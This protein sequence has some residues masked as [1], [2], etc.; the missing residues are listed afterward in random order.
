M[1]NKRRRRVVVSIL[2]FAAI[3][4]LDGCQKPGP[5][6]AASAPLELTVNSWVGWGPLF[7]AQEK[8]FFDGLNV[9][10]AFTEDAGARRSAMLAGQVDGYAS[11]VDNLAI[12]ATF[13]VTG[14]TV[15]CFDES[16]GADGIVARQN[17]TWAN[18][19]GHKVAVQK[20]LP[21][22]FL[23]L[24]ALA[25]HGLKPD[26]VAIL[27]LDADKAGSGFVSG[28]LDVA[29]TWE[30]WISKA[31]GMTGGKKLLTTAEMPGTIVDTLVM[32]DEV[33]LSRRADVKKVI[34]GW[35]KALEWYKTQPDEGNRII[36]AAYKLKPEEVKDIVAGIRFYDLAKN[37]EYMVGSPAGTAPIF[38][39]FDQASSL[40]KEAGV[41][42]TTVPAQRYI[43]S[44]LIVP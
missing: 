37:R 31:A 24:T 44:S 22:H 30:P 3:L 42:S 36:G 16:A 39:V 25:K 18:L 7:I 12:D 14:K 40:W 27:D 4:A 17:I 6:S 43:D 20:G 15:M 2:T 10:I 9:G 5:P 29:V 26:E 41:T 11:S 21:G 19:K 28:T 8:G 34:D 1:Q 38:K 35:F 33:L 32:R 13:G 23:L